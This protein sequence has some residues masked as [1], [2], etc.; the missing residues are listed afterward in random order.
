M[1]ALERLIAI[2]YIT[3]YKRHCNLSGK[4]TIALIGFVGAIAVWIVG[5]I[6]MHNKE[7]VLYSR[8]CDILKAS[9]QTY[10][11]IHY[12]LVSFLFV[13]SFV[14]LFIVVMMTNQKKASRALKEDSKRNFVLFMITGCSVLFVATPNV[15]LVLQDMDKLHL[16]DLTVGAFYC[17]YGISS[18]VNFFLYIAFRRDFRVR[19][20]QLFAGKCSSRLSMNAVA[21]TTVQS[22]FHSR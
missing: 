8:M 15:I 4:I 14:L 16:S 5:M 7:T 22:A 2:R 17:L 13:T 18:S 10:G 12:A 3:F 19:F 1:L 11:I 21:T 6:K 20:C 9:G